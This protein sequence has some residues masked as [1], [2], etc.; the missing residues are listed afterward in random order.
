MTTPTLTYNPNP[1]HPD[2]QLPSLACDSHVH[3]F[4]PADRFAYASSRN[5]TPVDAPKERLFDLHR[6]LGI[7][8]CVIVQSAVHGKCTFHR[9]WCTAWRRCWRKA[10]CQW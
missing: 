4:G 3:V 9:P 1:S 8:R 6:H 10:R 2:K 7:G 5:F